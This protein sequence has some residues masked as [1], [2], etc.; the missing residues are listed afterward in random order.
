MKGKKTTTLYRAIGC[1][2]CSH[3]GYRGRMGIY[4]VVE[5]DD[6]LRRMIHGGSSELDMELYTRKATS[7]IRDDG[8]TRILEGLT[9][10]D[11]VLRVT[12]ED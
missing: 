1:E 3:E 6:E 2:N 9:T 4:E 8:R 10:I 12:M 11:E 7:G 5:V